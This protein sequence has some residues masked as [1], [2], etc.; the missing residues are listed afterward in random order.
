MPEL[1]SRRRLVT[2]ITALGAGFVLTGCS[3]DKPEPVASSPT[4]STP[5]K[6]T[7]SP[8][9]SP[10]APLPKGNLNVLLIGSD[11][12][13]GKVREPGNGRADVIVMA[14]INAARDHVNLVSVARDTLVSTAD[15][16]GK[17]NETYVK[18]GAAGLTS[19]VS[20]LLGVK[21]PY[22]VELAFPQ[23]VT[24]VDLIG[25]Y[26]AYN[27]FAS[28]SMG[29]SFPKGTITL[30]TG[31]KA[32]AFVRERKGLP[33]GD[34]DRTER[35]RTSIIGISKKVRSLA[36]SDPA[37]FTQTATKIWDE[38]LVTGLTQA[39]ALELGIAL[40]RNSPAITSVMLPIAGFGMV[41]GASVDLVNKSRAAQL[42]KALAAGDVSKYAA[43]YGTSN[44][45]TG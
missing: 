10:T 45:P 16:R 19:A 22:S 34:L 25:G 27:R 17:V 39:Q 13:D 43:K 15:H 14:Q 31:K 23:F 35:A 30:K 44:A 11:S 9:P 8:A 38:L 3:S 42:T 18:D 26:S 5:P 4:P 12:R 6:P 21:I 7:A 41:N 29:V 28:N 36:T 32:L 40:A 37:G 1:V 24:M 33:N 2:G 20:S